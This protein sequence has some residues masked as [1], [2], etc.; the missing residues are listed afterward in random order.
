MQIHSDVN[1]AVKFNPKTQS[2]YPESNRMKIALVTDSAC[3]I[4]YEMAHAFQIKVVPNILVIEGKSVGVSRKV[5]SVR[6]VPH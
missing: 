2:V 4:P 5:F 1:P 3:D 6:E